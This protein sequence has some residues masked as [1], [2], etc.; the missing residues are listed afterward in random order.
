M[1]ESPGAAIPSNYSQCSTKQS[2]FTPLELTEA[3]HDHK[4]Y[5]AIRNRMSCYHN[6]RRSSLMGIQILGSEW[7]A[8]TVHGLHILPPVTVLDWPLLQTDTG[9]GILFLDGLEVG[10]EV[11]G[12]FV[13]GAQQ[14]AKDG[15]SR[16]TNT[17]KTSSW[18]MYAQ[19]EDIPLNLKS[20]TDNTMK[21]PYLGQKQ[22]AERCDNRRGW[23]RTR[24]KAISAFHAVPSC[25]HRKSIS[26]P[27]AM[28]TVKYTSPRLY[29]TQST[30][31]ISSKRSS[32]ALEPHAELG[33]SPPPPLLQLWRRSPSS[34][35]TQRFFFHSWRSPLLRFSSSPSLITL[36]GK[37][38]AALSRSLQTEPEY[39]KSSAGIRPKMCPLNT[40]A[41]RHSGKHTASLSS[42]KLWKCGLD[43][44]TFFFEA[45]PSHPLQNVEALRLSWRRCGHDSAE[46]ASCNSSSRDIAATVAREEGAQPTGPLQRER[47]IVIVMRGGKKKERGGDSAAG[48]LRQQRSG[49]T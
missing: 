46:K 13:L 40:H 19:K 27:V 49:M 14:R 15:V 41:T 35:S 43:I 5:E 2:T 1:S 21:G 6:Y 20:L 11:H 30:V 10:P 48:V 31:A 39:R 33:A 16:H 44:S 24:A 42:L 29:S 25:G 7:M 4:V 17:A 12:H 37:D 28:T 32:L 9:E 18:T 45:G 34:V 36:A 3:S 47:E 38:M 23:M 26:L 8:C 22:Q